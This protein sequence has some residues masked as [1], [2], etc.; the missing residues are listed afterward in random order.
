MPVRDRLP[1]ALFYLNPKEIATSLDLSNSL[2]W[3]RWLNGD[4][5][6]VVTIV[7]LLPDVASAIGAGSAHVLAE[8]RCLQKIRYKHRM[9]AGEAMRM[10]DAA[11]FGVIVWFERQ[12]PAFQFH[13][14]D[15]TSERR[16]KLVLKVIRGRPEVWVS[17]F[18][19]SDERTFNS[20]IRKGKL[21]K[22]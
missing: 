11:A 7:K 10:M 9:E 20:A 14:K 2:D 5:P 6:E 12:P 21:V 3:H 18:L 22:E 8:R 1:A 19:H 13:Y 16:Y 17:T 15:P 4:C